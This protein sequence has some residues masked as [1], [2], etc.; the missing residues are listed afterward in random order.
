MAE[1]DATLNLIAAQFTRYNVEKSGGRYVIVDCR[2]ADPVARLRP[3]EGTDRFELFYW[4]N[5][6]ERWTT[7]GNMGRMKLTLES[8]HEIVEGDPMFRVPRS[9]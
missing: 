6:K 9:R 3:I 5:V 1:P 4:S 8:A 2:T 7:F